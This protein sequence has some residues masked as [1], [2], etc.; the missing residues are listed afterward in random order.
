MTKGSSAKAITRPLRSASARSTS[1]WSLTIRKK[2]AT[3]VKS[4]I[5]V[6]FK[7]PEEDQRC[8]SLNWP[9][10]PASANALCGTANSRACSSRTETPCGHRDYPKRAI[11]RVILI[12]EL[13]AAG[14]HSKKIARLLPVCAPRT[15]PPTNALPPHCSAN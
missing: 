12:Q 15:A 2:H 9:A 13:L 10:T 8:E 5:S 11:D 3:T 4:D 6:R 14:P 7:P 1:Y